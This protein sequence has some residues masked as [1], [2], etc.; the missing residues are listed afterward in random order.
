MP[1]SD[2][3]TEAIEAPRSAHWKFWGTL[4]WGATILTIDIVSQIGAVLALVLWRESDIGKFSESELEQVALVTST[5]GLGLS[6]T[7]FVASTVCGGLIVSAI[8]LRRG[9]TLRAYLGI[10]PVPLA[11]LRN[12]LALLGG[13]LIVSMMLDILLGHTISSDFL[14][15]AYAT[16]NPAWPLWLAVVVVT[17]LYEEGIFRGFLLKG[18]AASFMGQTGAVV[19]TSAVW[20]AVHM[21]YDAYDM[22][23]I[24]CVGLLFG[25]ARLKTG[26][27]L[28]P[29]ALHAVTNLLATVE[30]AVFG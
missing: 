8:K 22:A 13:F 12:W 25:A 11:T 14:S 29:L 10:E 2:D 15:V 26:S 21:Q 19:L 24:F 4:I 1:A 17:P 5:S 28:V 6:V 3:T 23:T 20:A 16:A 9:L 7:T 18:F 27:I 30:V